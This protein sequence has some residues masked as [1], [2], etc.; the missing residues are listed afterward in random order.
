MFV[1]SLQLRE[2]AKPPDLHKWTKPPENLVKINFDG[3]FD[4]ATNSGGWG[5]VIRDHDGVFIAA[6]AG[7]SIHLRDALHSEVVAC[8]AAI[9]GAVRTGANRIIFESN[10]SSLVQALKSNDYDK[11]EIGV[12]VMEARSLCI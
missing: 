6:G 12:L 1:E 9:D 11:S 10:A 2:P 5:F 4:Q 8:L 7:K 3:A